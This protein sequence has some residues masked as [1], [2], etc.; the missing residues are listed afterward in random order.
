MP[1]R[2][3]RDNM[4]TTKLANGN[5][6]SSLVQRLPTHCCG[7]TSDTKQKDHRAQETILRDGSWNWTGD[8]NN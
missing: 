5:W 3:F 6:P 4:L 2:K 7:A 8:K 1:D